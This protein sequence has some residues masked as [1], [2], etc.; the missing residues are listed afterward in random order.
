LSVIEMPARRAVAYDFD[1][2]TARLTR[3][4]GEGGH[5]QQDRD[6]QSELQRHQGPAAAWAEEPEAEAEAKRARGSG[7]QALRVSW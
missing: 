3:E 2:S 4:R 6:C 1:E 7:S 5:P